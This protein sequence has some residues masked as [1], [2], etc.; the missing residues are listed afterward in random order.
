MA[1]IKVTEQT[2]RSEVLNAPGTVLVDFNADWCGPCRM[3][4]PVVEALSEELPDVK[5]VSVNVDDE[6]IL[7][8]DYDVS[9]IP[10]LV[11]FRNGEEVR[12]SVGAASKDEIAALTET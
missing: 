3:L 11:V 5:F 2:F 6:D 8:E 1:V 9:S 4:A 10:C 7:A 12:R